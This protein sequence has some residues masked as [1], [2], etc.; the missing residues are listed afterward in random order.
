M[1]SNNIIDVNDDITT[2]KEDDKVINSIDEYRNKNGT[3][4]RV[5]GYNLV[6]TIGKGQF[7]K[8]YLV[9]NSNQKRY[10]MKV[11][12]RQVPKKG[13]RNNGR[14]LVVNNDDDLIMNEVNIMK[15]L[16]HQHIVNLIAF[17][18]DNNASS[19]NVYLVIDYVDG[20]PVMIVKGLTNHGTPRFVCPVEDTVLGESRACSL[21]AQIFDAMSYLHHHGIAHRDIKMDN[22]MR[23]TITTVIVIIVIIVTFT[24]TIIIHHHNHNH[25]HH[26]H[27]HITIIIS[28]S[29]SSST[30]ITRFRRKHSSS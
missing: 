19:S 5:N 17:I 14:G 9:E 8:V 6:C 15:T 24:F 11:L 25:H 3:L 12:K 21:A 7:G 26:H 23:I 28:S 27:H 22:V 2:N 1:D 4:I 18:N 20:G 13:K 29:S 16:N 10:A 30:D